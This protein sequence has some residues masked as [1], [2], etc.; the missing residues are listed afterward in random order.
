MNLQTHIRNSLWLA[1]QSTYQSGNYSHAILDA[2]HYL[3]NVLRDKTGVDG[4]GA[5]LVGQALGGDPPRLRIN[6]LQTET[7]RNE[8]RGI[9]SILRGMYQA[10]RNPR[11]HEQIED[12]QETAD[13]IIYF[14]NY[15]LGIIEKS[16]E[17]FVLS[18]FIPCVF[19]PDF[20]KSQRYAELLVEKIP[21]NKRFDTLVTIYRDKLQG[22]IYNIGLVVRALIGNLPDEQVKNFLEVVSDEMSTITDEKEIR[23]NLHLLPPNLWE[24]LSETSRLRI[25]NRVIRAIKE[26]EAEGGNPKRG[27]LA[28]WARSHLQY[29]TLKDQV[30]MAFIV[31]LISSNS[32]SQRYVTELF[33]QQLPVVISLPYRRSQ[34]IKAISNSI[35]E[36]D[37][38]TRNALIRNIYELPDSWQK[39]FVKELKDMTD[40]N[41]PEIYLPDR[42]PFLKSSNPI[43]TDDELPF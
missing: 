31:K 25:E 10:I 22:D 15:L 36:D 28:T 19:D 29:F 6:R 16:E 12:S 9:E 18:K 4:D 34:C 14:I 23:Y 3:S 43:V 41:N 27:A 37:E 7:E 5:T 30:G 40:E 35:R 39:E 26:G 17:P 8:Q 13:A 38:A 11:S 33:L 20:V 1:I 2:M 32:A 42:T 21:T 24:Q